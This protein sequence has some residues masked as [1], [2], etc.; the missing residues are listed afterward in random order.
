VL[1]LPC[2][3]MIECV[4]STENGADVTLAIR[5]Q[6]DGRAY[7]LTVSP[8]QGVIKLAT[9]ASEWRRENCRI[10][11]SK[12]I[13]LR[14]FTDGTIV[15]CFVND[16]YAITRRVYDL[17]GGRARVESPGKVTIERFTLKAPSRPITSQHP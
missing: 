10:D 8:A 13:T 7:R 5:E 15:E 16:A 6:S 1:D 14:V 11:A 3:G 4:V 12:P 17:S 9:P 2:D